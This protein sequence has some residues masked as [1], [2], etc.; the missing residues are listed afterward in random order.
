MAGWAEGKA[1]R[2]KI[3]GTF[4][5]LQLNDFRVYLLF[6]KKKLVNFFLTEAQHAALQKAAREQGRSVSE[7]MRRS[8]DALLA[9]EL[10][11][12]RRELEKD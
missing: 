6:M 10:R 3:N 5:C 1:D 12:S 9:R 4:F 7:V 11:S 8:I 2:L